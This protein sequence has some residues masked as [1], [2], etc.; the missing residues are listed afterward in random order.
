MQRSVVFANQ[1]SSK[2]SAFATSYAEATARQ[3]SSDVT[4]LR[5]PPLRKLRR[6][7]DYDMASKTASQR[8]SKVHKVRCNFGCSRCKVVK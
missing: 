5:Q 8:R 2:A 3:E 7:M 1:L 4:C 6:S